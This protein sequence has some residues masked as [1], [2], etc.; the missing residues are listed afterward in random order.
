MGGEVLQQR[1][2]EETVLRVARTGQGFIAPTTESYEIVT[3]QGI[4][5]ASLFPH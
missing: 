2:H 1:F 5:H 3:T 4:I